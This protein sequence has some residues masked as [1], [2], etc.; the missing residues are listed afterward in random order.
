MTTTR[1]KARVTDIGE[2]IRN[3]SCQRRFKLACDNQRLYKTTLPFTDRP[4]H[5][6]DPVLSEAGRLR[7]D[8]WAL[9]LEDAGLARVPA[10]AAGA[11]PLPWDELVQALRSV[12]AGRDA[13]AREVDIQGPIGCFE[14]SGR[15]DFV[16]LR[17]RGG[18]PT[19]R[20][21][22]CKASRR[23]RTYQRVQVTLYRL[24]VQERLAEAP[25]TLAGRRLAPEDVECVVAR[26]DEESNRIQSILELAPFPMLHAVEADVRRLLAAGGPLDRLLD[27]P[28]DDLSYRLEGKCDDCVFSVHCFAESARQRRLELLGVSPVTARALRRAGV[29]TLDELAD[30]DEQGEVAHQMRED[31]DFTEHLESLIIRARAR[32]A[33]L[34]ARP[35]CDPARDRA[36][37]SLPFTGRGQ[38][39]L[40]EHDGRRLVRV[41]LTVS[42]DY[43][44]NR[45]GALS[46]HVTDSDHHLYTPFA[47]QPDGKRRPSPEVVEV[48]REPD[49]VTERPRVVSQRPPRGIDLVAFQSV[50]W[51]GIYERDN[52][53]EM[54]LLQGFLRRVVDAITQVAGAAEAPIHF[55][56]W[57]RSE[58]ARLLE[59][60]SRASAGLMHHLQQLLGCRPGLEQ[61]IYSCLQDELGN[62][63]AAGWTSRGLTVATAL[64]W[65]GQRYHWLRRV[66]YH[67]QEVDLERLFSRDLFD[68]RSRLAYDPADPD[69]AWHK[70]DTAPGAAT[71]RFEVR[72]RFYD[73]LSAPYW[74]AYWGTLTR[75][76]GYGK[77]HDLAQAAREY[78][79]ASK[80][81]NLDAYLVARA[82]ALRFLDERV[83]YKNP[84]LTKPPFRM[85]D[86]P[87]FTLRTS[88][89]AE[90]ARDFLRLGRPGSST[91]TATRRSRSGS[92]RTWTRAWA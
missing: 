27:Q 31:P 59:A 15:I 26:L 83:R 79:R 66:G 91:G 43:V 68:F 62:R 67:Q 14:L 6:I 28:L 1:R 46:A 12:P 32:R 29:R 48:R 53:A 3:D 34:P 24:L 23:D 85:E 70:D 38:L 13:F 21:V 20:L 49:P 47:P 80:S 55:Y 61:L 54:Q 42:Y 89:A 7:E 17:W 57:S 84:K 2:Y 41:Y 11:D 56:V 69:H 5:V 63:Y 9:A 82:Q 16:L 76:A 44:E 88:D 75:P 81:E 86:L 8:Q 60:C 92:W 36:V 40:H 19:L 58:I 4:F 90:A 37:L 35:G 78:Y 65:F 64:T 45:I 74:R 72:G 51:T 77:R 22:E 87:D 50:P 73:S 39:P 25:L 18:R 52:G 30:L 10:G 71:H 33:T